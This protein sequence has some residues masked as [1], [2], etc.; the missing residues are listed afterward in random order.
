VTTPEPLRV[1]IADDHPF[2][3]QGLAKL[4][5]KSG[6]KVVGQAANGIEAIEAV[7]ANAPDVIVM[8][9]NMPGLSGAEATRRLNERNP[10]TKVLVL[11]VSAEEQDVTEAILSGA[12]GYLLKD[13]PVEEVVAGIKAVAAGESLISPRIASMLLLT[14]RDRETLEAAPPPIPLSD[15]ELQVLKLVSGGK[16]NREIAAALF[17]DSSTVRNHM[18]SILMKLQVD[19]RVQAAVRGVRDRLV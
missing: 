1:V 12:N 9:L 6:V 11:S 4:L 10:A 5:E 18:S 14:V 8:D 13:G 17:I 2:F 7:E 15:R 16:T 3:R 19:N